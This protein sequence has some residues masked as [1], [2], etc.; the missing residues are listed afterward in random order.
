MAAN[1]TTG[2]PYPLVGF[3]FSISFSGIADTNDLKFKAVSGISM[4]L[5]VE[6]VAQGG[7]SGTFVTLPKKTTFSDLEL[8]RGVLSAS[9][10]VTAWCYSWLLNDYSQP[11]EKKTVTLKLL[12][13]DSTPV[14]TWQFNEAYPVQLDISSFSSTAEGEAALVVE[15][16]KLKYSTIQI[17]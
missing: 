3:Y 5:E 14:M 7:D 1:Q 4:S 8:K 15:S 16:I 9:S 12:S 2:E 10:A 13:K 6:N 17:I 11:I